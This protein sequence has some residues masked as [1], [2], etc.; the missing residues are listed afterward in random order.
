MKQFKLSLKEISDIVI[1]HYKR[2]GYFGIN[3]TMRELSPHG[4]GFE[5]TIE[6][7]NENPCYVNEED[8]IPVKT[9]KYGKIQR[10]TVSVDAPY[11]NFD[12]RFAEATE[13]IDE[14]IDIL[15]MTPIE[16][17]DTDDGIREKYLVIYRDIIEL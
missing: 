3:C 6:V 12:M 7:E 10:R 13:W 9:I 14:T 8:K 1:E 17:K 4:D 2:K 11:Y 5:T 16:R 15:S